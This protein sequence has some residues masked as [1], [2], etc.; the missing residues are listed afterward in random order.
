MSIWRNRDGAQGSVVGNVTSAQA[1]WFV[2]AAAGDLH[3]NSSA[4]AA[5][6]RATTLVDVSDD[7]DGD[8]RPIGPAPDIGA[9]EYY[10]FVP[11]YRCFLP[12]VTR[13]S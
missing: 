7:Y 10:V 8:A 5:I 2:D 3:L 1:S 9:D 11:R 6:D 4:T 13:S 12:V